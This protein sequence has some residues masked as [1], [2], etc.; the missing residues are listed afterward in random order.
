MGLAH[1]ISGLAR[2]TPIAITI[3]MVLTV[4]AFLTVQSPAE[5]MQYEMVTY[6][7]Y[8]IGYYAAGTLQAIAEFEA[9]GTPLTWS[10]ITQSPDHWLSPLSFMA[11]QFGFGTLL[12]WLGALADGAVPIIKG[13]QTRHRLQSPII[14]L[15]RT[16]GK[17]ICSKNKGPQNEFES[18]VNKQLVLESRRVVENELFEELPKEKMEEVVEGNG[19]VL[20]NISKVFGKYNR[21]AVHNLTMTLLE[22][23]I[24]VLLGPNGAGKST[25]FQILNG[26]LSA[27]AGEAYIYGKSTKSKD[28]MLDIRQHLGVCPQ[29]NVL[30]PNFTVREHI[31]L[32]EG[33]KGED[34]ATEDERIEALVEQVGL[35]D[36]LHTPSSAL[37]GG[38][39]RRLQLAIALC[40]GSKF[41]IIDEVTSGVDPKSR[42]LI[43]ETV[44]KFREGRTIL[45][46]THYLEEADLLGDRI[47]ILANGSLQAMGTSLF[48]KKNTGIGYEMAIKLETEVKSPEE[49]VSIVQSK[50]PSAALSSTCGKELL[51]KLPLDASGFSEM[52]RILDDSKTSLG[53]KTVDLK[54]SSLGSAFLAVA[55][56]AE[57]SYLKASTRV[58]DLHSASV[59]IESK[60]LPSMIGDKSLRS[61]TKWLIRKRFLI[62]KRNKCTWF[63][64]LFLPLLFAILALVAALTAKTTL[65]LEAVVFNADSHW[66]SGSGNGVPIPSTIG[67]GLSVNNASTNKWITSLEVNDKDIG[68][69]ALVGP[70][71]TYCIDKAYVAE[72]V[73]FLTDHGVSS[74]LISLAASTPTC[75]AAD[76]YPLTTAAFSEFLKTSRDPTGASTYGA[77]LFGVLPDNFETGTV[78]TNVT[79]EYTVAFNYTGIHAAP[80]LAN[81]ANGALLS[82]YKPGYSITTESLAFQ[83]TEEQEQL[84]ETF[85]GIGIALAIVL[86]TA[87]L[88][89]SFSEFIVREKQSKAWHQQLLNGI[90]DRAYWISNW[91]YDYTT[92]MLYVVL[93]FAIAAAMQLQGIG[94]NFGALM[95][96]SFV[97]GLAIASFIYFTTFFFTDAGYAH[98]GGVAVSLLFGLLLVVV[99][100]SL[101]F[102]EGTREVAEILEYVFGLVPIY[103]FAYGCA[104]AV[105]LDLWQIV[106]NTKAFGGDPSN[107]THFTTFSWKV[108]GKSLAM[109]G[110]DAVLYTLLLLWFQLRFRDGVFRW[111]TLF[112]CSPKPRNNVDQVDVV[113]NPVKQQL[114]STVHEET[115]RVASGVDDAITIRNVSKVYAGGHAAVKS[116][117]LGIPEGECFGFLGCNGAG[118]TSTMSMVAG[119]LPITSG[120]ITVGGFDVSTNTAEAQNNL[121]YCPQFDALFDYLTV[122]E[123]LVFYATMQGF[124]DE[125][126]A[127]VV[128]AKVRDLDLEKHRTKKARELSGGNKR[129]LSVAIATIGFPKAVV[130]DE[131]SSGMDI[132]TMRSL[133]AYIVKLRQSAGVMLS[134][135]SMSEVSACSTRIGILTSGRFRALGSANQ[136]IDKFGEGWLLEIILDE[137]DSVSMKQAADRVTAFLEENLPGASLSD[138]HSKRLRY[139]LPTNATPIHEMFDILQSNKQQLEISSYSLGPETLEDIFIKFA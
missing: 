84:G 102:N 66:N 42:A 82:A 113:Y 109:L 52:L 57:K 112:C 79:A 16:L 80:L 105:S 72:N 48:L 51:M 75:G 55:D 61:Q 20:Q 124:E 94:E 58:S 10:V 114:D 59:R 127:R 27:T 104:N 69:R 6:S 131:P 92:F 83:V 19:V 54:A 70:T 18:I 37:S 21:K 45:M 39:K 7:F 100:W 123:H 5:N 35:F 132:G 118:K 11:F 4:L 117:S 36:K 22:N 136:L 122:E 24:T 103:A 71:G 99:T 81:R 1:F 31:V 138:F 125:F 62:L 53:I 119:D 67:D 135:H 68:L 77:L 12:F 93:V 89:S 106:Y 26:L 85:S 65:D 50:V 23:Q 14:G 34:V 73:Q 28:E 101:K 74:D 130:L 9:W 17:L 120:T 47:G 128:D 56:Q 2:N 64:Q 3:F 91:M 87:F 46:S 32:F 40:G 98:L 30:I 33:I 88:T 129:K 25:T 96:I 15:F 29:E 110:I 44:L 126:L 90:S 108:A 38:M 111:R 137:M 43:Q 97:A 139:K 86:G 95:V 13:S 41:I 49:I 133:R 107:P 134:S 78:P 63:C 121:G 60:L 116:I 76:V 8:Y 115:I